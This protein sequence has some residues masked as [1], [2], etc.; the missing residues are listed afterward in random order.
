MADWRFGRHCEGVKDGQQGRDGCFRWQR[1]AEGG[2]KS[3]NRSQHPRSRVG[4]R[5]KHNQPQVAE[6]KHGLARHSTVRYGEPLWSRASSALTPAALSSVSAGQLHFA[7]SLS[8]APSSQGPPSRPAQISSPQP[9]VTPIA[10]PP[11]VP[12]TPAA[13]VFSRSDC[14]CHK[15]V[16]P[17]DPS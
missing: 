16:H 4:M 17:S 13:V 10:H 15:T 8:W 11:L 1:G 3:Q 12:R 2:F 14:R 5:I 7:V 9:T 6:E